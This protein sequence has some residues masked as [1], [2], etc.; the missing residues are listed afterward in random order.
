MP[1]GDEVGLVGELHQRVAP[2]EED[3]VERHARLG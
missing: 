3:G 1:R 2:V